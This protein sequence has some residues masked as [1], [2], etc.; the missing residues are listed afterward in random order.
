MAGADE[1]L[2]TLGGGIAV[3]G[4]LVAVEVWRLSCSVDSARRTVKDVRRVLLVLA[5]GAV[6]LTVL[7]APAAAHSGSGDTRSLPVAAAGFTVLVA[8]LVL[9]FFWDRRRRSASGKRGRR[10]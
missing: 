9:S 6:A 2:G 3:P 4:R 5:L 1:E 7:A 8:A 10:G